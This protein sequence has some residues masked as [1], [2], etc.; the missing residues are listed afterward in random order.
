MGLGGWTNCAI[1][2]PLLC[3]GNVE[4]LLVELKLLFSEERLTLL[5]VLLLFCDD[6]STFGAEVLRP[7]LG[8]GIAGLMKRSLRRP[9]KRWNFS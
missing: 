5:P 8:S 6:A 9:C 4:L 7:R 2:W 3:D 1:W